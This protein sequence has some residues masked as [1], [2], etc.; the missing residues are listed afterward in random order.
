M[1]NE[2]A[3]CLQEGVASVGDIDLA[4]MAGTGYP[5]DKGGPLKYADSLGIDQ[6]LRVI[7]ELAAQIGLRYW[8]APLLKRMVAAGH[9]GVKSGQG[10]YHYA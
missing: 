3:I 9:L 4:M 2:A 7:Q 1:I 6:V 5:Q 10:F 8:P